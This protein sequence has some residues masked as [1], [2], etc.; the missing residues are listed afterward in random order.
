MR[1][2]ELEVPGVRGPGPV[3]LCPNQ[4][5]TRVGA[6]CGGRS[7]QARAV[8]A[9]LPGTQTKAR[10]PTLREGEDSAWLPHC[11]GCP[12][13]E[14]PGATWAQPQ[15]LAQQ[16]WAASH[17]TAIRLCD[18]LYW[19]TVCQQL[20]L[21]ERPRCAYKAFCVLPS[22]PSPTRT[23]T[24]PD[25][26]SSPGDQLQPKG[27]EEGGQRLSGPPRQHPLTSCPVS[28]SPWRY[29]GCPEVWGQRQPGLLCGEVVGWGRRDPAKERTLACGVSSSVCPHTTRP[30]SIC[31]QVSVS[32][33]GKFM[34]Q[35]QET[36]RP[37]AS[38]SV[39]EGWGWPRTWCMVV[40]GHS[41]G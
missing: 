21:A 27:S 39:L 10:V 16:R 1:E 8:Q 4:G 33:L 9:Q 24:L 26:V 41:S 38:A 29:G 6:S 14:L 12:R 2:N 11:T 18:C 22:T 20:L 40:Q 19:Q 17:L 23:A 15:G 34:G 36:W 7:L 5:T 3:Q 35:F 37:W 32:C 31:Y 28:H 30:I 13:E 25:F